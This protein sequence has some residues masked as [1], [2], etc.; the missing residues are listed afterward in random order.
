MNDKN[1]SIDDDKYALFNGLCRHELTAERIIDAISD[2]G[3]T[4]L[5]RNRDGYYIDN[6]DEFFGEDD[7]IDVPEQ[8]AQEIIAGPCI[9]STKR[10]GIMVYQRNL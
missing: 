1:R 6:L 9:R 3:I 10:A 2:E 7:T 5:C 8:M 4:A